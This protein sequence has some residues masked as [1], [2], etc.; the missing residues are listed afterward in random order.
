[1]LVG[2]LAALVTGLSKTAVPGA[3]LLAV[4][5]FATIASGRL[6]A[7][8]TLPVLIVA[9]LFAVTWYHRHARWDQIRPIVP[10]VA[11]GYAAGVAFFV[12]VGSRTR[13]VE[14]VIGGAV[15]V[16][17]ALQVWRMRRRRRR[18]PRPLGRRDQAIY[19]SAGGF[20]TFVANASGPIVNTYFVSLGLDRRELV[21]TSAWFYFAVN[22]SKVPVYVAIAALATGGP[23]FTGQSL[24]FDAAVAPAVVVGALVGRAVLHRMP[25]RVFVVLVLA[26]S[27]AGAVRLLLG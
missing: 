2:L 26:L 15:L 8:I 6:I 9:D 27:A 14:L 3:G 13:P 1:M 4:P 12:V 7:G 24:V 18:A 17:V 20:T 11:L 23:F 25:E 22:V 10:W 5:L 16:M 21:G 19:G